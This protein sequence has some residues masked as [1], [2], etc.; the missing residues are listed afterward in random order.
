MQRT[1]FRRTILFQLLVALACVWGPPKAQA[2]DSLEYVCMLQSY[3]PNGHSLHLVNLPGTPSPEYHFE[4]PGGLM[5]LYSDSVVII[6]GR[7]IHDTNPNL[8]WDVQMV[9]RD[10]RTYAQWAALGR[11]YK[12][13]LAPIDTVNAYVNTWGF[14]E[15]DSLESYLS[16]VPGTYY[17]GDT[18]TL[19]HMPAN[20]QF[21]FQFGKGANSK[22]GD[23]GLS[24]WFF[25]NGSYSGTG[26][27]NVNNT[28]CPAVCDLSIDSLYTQC[29]SDSTFE[30]VASFSGT[31]AHYRVSDNITGS[32]LSDTTSGTYTFGPYANQTQVIFTFEDG[33]IPG[34]DTL[35]AP[36][37]AD[38]TPCSVG[39]DSVSTIC[40]TDSTFE[41]IVSFTGY[42]NQ[43]I[44]S[45]DQGS[46]PMG[47]LASGTYSFGH[48]ANGTQVSVTVANAT[49]ASCV[50]VSGPFTDDCT[51]PC[52]VNL[53]S[54]TTVCLTDSTFGLIVTFTGNR[55]DFRIKDNQGTAALTGLSAGTYTYGEYTNGTLVQV[56]VKSAS[57]PQCASSLPPVTDDCTPPCTIDVDSVSTV[58]LTDSTFGLVITFTGNRTDYQ[59][60]D[61]QSST[62]LTGLAS[63]TYAFG[64]YA[65]NSQVTLSVTS[66][67]DTA[68]TETTG[69]YTDD[70]TP[71]C[72]IDIDSVSTVCLTDSTFGLV[73]TFTGNR[74]DYEIADDQNS[75]PL[76][77]L[78]SG[79]YA[80]GSYANNTPV[81]I[82]VTSASDAAC[83][84]TAGTYTDDCTPPC[85]IDIDSV[86]TV[87]LTDSTFGLVVTF[88]G[89][90]TDYEIADDQ[91]SAPLTG[92]S[93]GTYAFGSYANNT[94][95]SISV[96]SASDAACTETAGTYTDDCTPPCTIDI[97]SVSTVCLTDST[98]GL[99]VTFT[100]NRTDYEIADDQNSAPLTGLSSGTYAFGSYANNTPVSISVT[101]A[102]DVACTET[103][104]PYTDDCTPPCTID[105]D[106]V[107]T[108]CLTDSTFGLVV[109]FTGNRTDYEIADDQNSA[110]LTGLSSGTYAFGSYANNTPVSI[111]V[112]SASDA[113]CTE[114]AGPYTDDCTPPCTIDIDSV[115]T[116]C[117]TDSTFGLV[118]TFTGNRTDYEIADDQNSAPLTGLSSGTYA[119]GSYANNTPV[120]I[121]VTS[122]SDAAC[123]ESAGPYTDDCTPPC[124]IDIDSVSTVCLTDSTFGL[125]VTFTGNRTDYEIADDQ[126]SASLTGLSSGTYAFGSYANNTPVSISVTSASDA[127]CTESAGPYTDDCTPPCYVNL[128]SVI[129]V[130]LSDSTFGLMV[131]FTGNRTD[132]RIQDSQGTTPLTG[133]SQGT[134]SYGE[135]PNGTL[136][137]A[138]VKSASDPQCASSLPPVTDDCTPPCTIDIDSV[139]TVCLTDST[140]G[141]IVTITGNRTDYEIADD[142]N[143]APLTGLSSGTY[144]FGAYA[145]NT[146][147]NI[148]VTSA[149]DA[150][151]TEQAGP[152]TDD[153]TPPC[154]VN[155]DSVITVCLS[156]STFG[157]IVT[158]TGNR[159]DFRIKDNQG[160]VALTGLS[161]GTYA[162]GSYPNGTVVKINVK[163]I[164]DPQC[165]AVESGLTTDCSPPCSVAIDSVYT[166]CLTD[167][168]FEVM[169]SFTGNEANYQITDDQNTAPITGLASGTY[170]FGTYANDTQVSIAVT[171]VDDS[172]CTD[173][174]G[175][176]TDNCTPPCSVNLDS[177]IT[178][179]LTDSTFGVIVTFTGVGNDFRI[180]D[181][182]GT[183]PL[184][185]LSQGTYSYGVYP[186]GTLVQ[187]SVKSASDLQ[188]ASSLPPVTDD[189]T[190][191][192][193]VTI[194]SVTTTCVNNSMFD[195]TISFSGT[196]SYNLEDLNGFVYL[197]NIPAGSYLISSLASDSVYNFLVRD[198][199]AGCADSVFNIT[200]SCKTTC[201]LMLDTL[202]A[203]C[204]TDSTFIVYVGISGTGNNFS[205]QDDQGN[206]LVDSLGAGLHAIGPYLNST[207]VN[208]IVS[209]WD[210]VNCVDSAGPVTGDCVPV[211]LCDIAIDTA[212]TQC[213]SDTTFEVV[214]TVSATATSITIADLLN[215]VNISGVLPG[216]YNL[217]PY[218]NGD[219]VA[220]LAADPSQ[221]QCFDTW[222]I[223]TMDCTPGPENEFCDDPL[224]IYCGNSY[225]GTTEGTK[226]LNGGLP[227]CTT[228]PSAF[229]LWY[230][231]VGTGDVVKL[232]TC[233]KTEMPANINV[234]TGDCTTGW[235]CV[236]GSLKKCS[237]VGVDFEFLSEVGEIYMIYIS[238]TNGT[239]GEVEL[240][241]ECRNPQ[242]PAPVLEATAL[243]NVI[244]VTWETAREVHTTGFEV[245]RSV[246]Q[247][248]TYEPIA[249]VPSVGNSAVPTFYEYKD[250]D[251][252]LG[253]NHTYY[254]V[255]HNVYGDEFTSNEDEATLTLDDKWI[256]R[257]IYP[258]PAGTEAIVP[259]EVERSVVMTTDL[260]DGQGRVVRKFQHSLKTGKQ[261]VHLTLQG[262]APGM[263]TVR[264][265]ATDH[266]AVTQKLVIIR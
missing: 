78:S 91:N 252:T 57:D 142:Q 88:T 213:L 84:E 161:Q 145:N 263:Y 58:C 80:F 180:Q 150:S 207:E 158:F 162:Y 187:V 214:V 46:T 106:S 129:T 22:T 245:F 107:S 29:L 69:P 34:C 115:S 198:L 255:M 68:C 140:F 250:T 124:T 90:R 118:V 134:Y 75:A 98:F 77:G 170:A 216:T 51:P 166:V 109:T 10:G 169:V 105:I 24:G 261:N 243:R 7:V 242:V 73:V 254:V 120:S 26:D 112:T 39:I 138:S 153:C 168:T 1:L 155:L 8:Q 175:P 127:A 17:D 173:M 111:S 60:T 248:M 234:Y 235:T 186:N 35:T 190:P 100:G 225:R 239:D 99:V 174:A 265:H 139:S 102:S 108:V 54:V 12:V 27:I 253:I 48:Y 188:C 71:P 260:I 149:S 2:Q 218:D 49:E 95:V 194:D 215:P 117:L 189:C 226:G 183:A 236:S 53:D 227:S 56:S 9:L 72:T 135:Y 62:P 264:C 156:D 86:S 121:S 251:V 206:P 165:V 21:G 103:A 246:N 70:C 240:S 177:V 104:G 256:I 244:S 199:A 191:P 160:T 47:S 230:R 74:T 147:V 201:D 18:L 122:A 193:L 43:F 212:Y 50:D 146:Q 151:C 184:T 141:V 182:Q 85:T 41:L 89:N 238:R 55:T 82:S 266:D 3:A 176:F 61:N 171:S 5:H 97:D 163:S 38:C 25:Y 128:D 113:A 126:N 167:S 192:C 96:T 219:N 6:T 223:L 44:L 114:T 231:Y 209:D 154:N 220:L 130:C 16:G 63:G 14:Y 33:L 133:L 87:C 45:D 185:G 67:S 204:F 4:A 30:V 131:S 233:G 31:S 249:W 152:F 52:T 164:G 148:S 222:S 211:Q 172:T 32:L 123:T 157:L 229:G 116:V 110:P 143:S 262:L 101:S 42:G 81:S 13:E 159:N 11:G 195:A 20:R 94:P 203:E 228:T 28:C 76:T 258:N 224:D 136:V 232:S 202:Y 19:N 181:S 137:Q 196:G 83:T 64:S 40:V 205:V 247:G 93:S 119:F 241:I 37:T 200:D 132:F 59:I 15:M 259:V 23:F 125:V 221:F 210:F 79:T 237:N 92:L 65:N 178:V 257:D 66:A 179:C 36:I 217:G 197:P 208:V 144:A